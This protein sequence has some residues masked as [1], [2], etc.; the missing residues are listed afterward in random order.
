MLIVSCSIF[1][2][3]KKIVR[4]EIV[5][6]ET[7]NINY[8]HD[9]NVN[10]YAV[11]D[12]GKRKNITGKSELEIN[13]KGGN[14]EDDMVRIDAY[15]TNWKADTVHIEAVYKT[16]IDTFAHEVR[17]P[18]NYKG[19]I[20]LDFS[21]QAGAKGSN[22]TNRGTPLVFRDGNDGEDGEQGADGKPGNDLAV[23]VW[24]D[25]SDGKYRIKIT[26]LMTNTNYYYTYLYT[27]SPFIIMANGGVGG[28]GGNGGDGGTGK[29]GVVKDNKDKRPGDGGNGG[30][31]GTGGSGGSGGTVY[32]TFHPNAIAL[33]D[34][35]TV[36]NFGGDGG[37]GGLAG[38]AGKPGDPAEGQDNGEPGT[39]G[40]PGIM[41]QMGSIGQTVILVETFDFEFE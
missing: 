35:I 31:G 17:I 15:P 4:V 21:G 27:G 13:V 28:E 12:N 34:K 41:G 14:F 36:H 32:L 40:I 25:T 3:N 33:R 22:G 2:S 10:V 24:K 5:H 37:Q 18:F 6:D 26:N 19:E 20:N 29:D 8:G 9:F 30:N 11:F 23:L 7:A 39:E 16:E 1:K 38:E